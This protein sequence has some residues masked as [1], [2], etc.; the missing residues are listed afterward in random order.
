MPVCFITISEKVKE[1]SS[2]DFDFIKK[3]VAS[4]LDSSSRKLDETHIALR[5]INGTR[6][7]MLG[8]IEVD[9][10][11]QLYIPRFFSRDRRANQISKAIST[12]F[13]CCCATWINLNY[14]GYSRVD[15][16]CEYYS[17]SDNHFI[18]ILQR[19]RGIYTHKRNNSSS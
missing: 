4:G 11:A 16:E 2:C 3:T 9:I 17:D 13:D 1:L 8:D 18:R 7:N 6:S 10:F 19:L 15:R 14:V 12:Q 5:I